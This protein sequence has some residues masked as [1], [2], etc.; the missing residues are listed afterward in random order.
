[1]QSAMAAGERIFEVLDVPVLVGGGAV[2]DE[3]AARRLR[4]AAAEAG[5]DAE[6]IQVARPGPTAS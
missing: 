1:M 6:Q 3:S 5:A 4:D 2:A